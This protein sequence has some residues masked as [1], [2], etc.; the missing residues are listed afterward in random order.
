MTDAAKKKTRR[1][2]H[3]QGGAVLAS[4]GNVRLDAR[5]Q[6]EAFVQLRWTELLR[7]LRKGLDDQTLRE[8]SEAPSD[9]EALVLSLLRSPPE[10]T[11]GDPLLGAKLRGLQ[12]RRQLIEQ[13]G[14]LLTTTQVAKLLNLTNQAVLKRADQNKLVDITQERRGHYFPAFQFTQEGKVVA[15]I[16][17]VLSELAKGSHAGWAAV[18]FFVSGNERLDG[19]TPL[20]VLK[21]GDV[22]AVVRAAD[23]YGEQG[24]A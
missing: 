21:A 22:A 4:T 24:S 19:R 18:T 7:T 23:W 9:F 8:A 16:P 17:E 1:P 15:G 12:A 14:G 10:I 6:L 11:A 13:S 5:G 20:E 3:L 2:V